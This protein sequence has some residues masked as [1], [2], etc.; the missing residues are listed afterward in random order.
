MF[1]VTIY[2]LKEGDIFFAH[3]S[4]LS[5]EVSGIT[6][7][8]THR[9]VKITCIGAENVKPLQTVNFVGLEFE[10]LAFNHGFI[11]FE[12]LKYL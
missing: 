12:T 6:W 5:T 2:V 1:I 3:K 4:F 11:L 8:L 10:K 9:I 7:Y